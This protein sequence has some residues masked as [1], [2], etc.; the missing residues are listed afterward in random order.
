MKPLTLKKE[1]AIEDADPK[2]LTRTLLESTHL[3]H[4]S[5]EDLLSLIQLAQRLKVPN[6]NIHPVGIFQYDTGKSRRSEA[7]EF[8]LEALRTVKYLEDCKGFDEAIKGFANGPQVEST[9]FEFATAAHVREL[10]ACKGIELSPPTPGKKKAC[11]FVADIDGIGTIY[12]ECKKI[13]PNEDKRST[14]FL[15][16]CAIISEKIKVIE[17]QEDVRIDI[18]LMEIN[19]ANFE[20]R[21]KIILDA[22]QDAIH[23][24]NNEIF[25]LDFCKIKIGK[26]TEPLPF[27][28]FTTRQFAIKVTDKPTLLDEPNYYL[29]INYKDVQRKRR[30]ASLIREANSQLPREHPSFIALGYPNSEFGGDLILQAIGRKENTHLLGIST[31]SKGVKFYYRTA[32]ADKIKLLLN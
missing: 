12:W 10:K 26:K 30:V 8:F 24:K 2:A 22:I 27:Q 18:L 17:L 19:R 7:V 20:N 1:I 25:D 15:E 6:L 5:S 9:F 28:D 11:D 16:L 23:K 21:A 13:P 32:D 4:Y 14:R 29:T 31:W 3:Q